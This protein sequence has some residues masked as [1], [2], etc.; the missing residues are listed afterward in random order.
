MTRRSP[1]LT[2]DFVD[3]A[4]QY[5]ESL[6]GDDAT[7]LC[8]PSVRGAV[9]EGDTFVL[10]VQHPQNEDAT[11]LLYATITDRMGDDIEATIV[12]ARRIVQAGSFVD[13]ECCETEQPPRSL[14][15][16]DVVQCSV[17]HVGWVVDPKRIREKLEWSDKRRKL[18]DEHRARSE[19][20]QQSQQ[21]LKEACKLAKG[22]AVKVEPLL[23]QRERKLV[24]EE[25]KQS[26]KGSTVTA[27]EVD[28]KGDAFLYV[29]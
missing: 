15:E 25:K 27:E 2:L 1:E 5:A 22:S 17:K 23:L 29:L 14:Y 24:Q 26:E 12:D 7:S 13:D 21:R 10:A 4:A 9:K 11:E 18:L 16:G 6:H 8:P 28:R 20:P 19:R 3:C